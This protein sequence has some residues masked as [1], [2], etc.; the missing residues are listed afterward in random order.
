MTAPSPQNPGLTNWLLITGLGV[1]WGA[2]FMAMALALEGFGY[3][4]VAALRLGIGALAL[5][6]IGTA[7]GQGPGKITE[8]AGRRG[9]LFAIGTGLQAY[10]LPFAL[11]TWGL[12]HVPSAFAGV[13]MGML[14]LLVLPL[15][16]IFSPEEG[17]GP[18][19]IVGVSLGFV[20]LLVLFGP[21]AFEGDDS[22]LGLLGR[23]ACFGAACCYAIGSVATRRA[24]NMPPLAFSSASLAAAALIVI[25]IALW[26]EGMPD[27]WPTRPTLAVLFAA[28][29]PTALAAA[30]RV[31]VITTAGTLFMTLT[32][33]MVPVWAIIFGIV[34]LDEALPPQLF[35]A[36]ALILTGIAISQNR[37]LRQSF[38]RRRKED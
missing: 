35:V 13:T 26:M 6:L 25:P 24:P 5:T 1:I 3:W 28:L 2:A 14:P 31:R 17:I 38:A 23:L 16:A 8:T 10:A 37:A 15:V 22:R 29:F 4:T 18:R 11:L 21:S 19:R 32:N 7:M 9:W 33:Y 12:Q 34:I 20:G 27:A 36:L 30:V